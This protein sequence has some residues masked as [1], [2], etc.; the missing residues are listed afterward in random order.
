MP[1]STAERRTLADI[2]ME[3]LKEVQGGGGGASGSGSM[4]DGLT[5]PVV[6]G[7]RG[8]M[9]AKVIEV[10]TEVRFASFV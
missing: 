4:V 8:G 3:K 2:I 10:Y 9:D 5:G 6:G 7:Q 1:E